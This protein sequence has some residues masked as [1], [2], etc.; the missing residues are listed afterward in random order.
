MR[1]QCTATY[2]LHSF[3]R[4]L[5]LVCVSCFCVSNAQVNVLNVWH[6]PKYLA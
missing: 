3:M 2:V 4:N 5:F 6:K 1:V